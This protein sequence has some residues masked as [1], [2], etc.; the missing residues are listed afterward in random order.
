MSDAPLTPEQLQEKL[1][2]IH[3]ADANAHIDMSDQSQGP[4]TPT[5]Y[6]MKHPQVIEGPACLYDLFVLDERDDNFGLVLA[7]IE[8]IDALL[9]HISHLE[10]RVEELR[11]AIG[12]VKKQATDYPYGHTVLQPF[13][14]IATS[15]LNQS[16]AEPTEDAR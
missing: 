6:Q 2:I 13:Y 7:A 9:A 8:T 10:G 16:T 3:H 15:A 11:A 12:E 1:R 5:D 14:D 4:G